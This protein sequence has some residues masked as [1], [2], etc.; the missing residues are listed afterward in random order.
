METNNSKN[1]LEAES[2]PKNF[3]SDFDESIQSQTKILKGL[4]RECL[5]SDYHIEDSFLSYQRSY[6]KNGI[7]LV[8]YIHFD[9]SSDIYVLPELMTA[10]FWNEEIAI[11]GLLNG[12]CVYFLGQKKNKSQNHTFCSNHPQLVQIVQ[13]N[14]KIRFH[15]DFHYLS[16]PG[17]DRISE[18]VGIRLLNDKSQFLTIRNSGKIASY[19]RT[20]EPFGSR[21][22]QNQ[23]LDFQPE[24]FQPIKSL[25]LKLSS[26]APGTGTSVFIKNKVT[27]IVYEEE[28]FAL[29]SFDF[30][31]PNES[32]SFI[33]N[34]KEKIKI[35]GSASGKIYF[36]FEGNVFQIQELDQTLD[37]SIL[38]IVPAYYS[39]Y[40]NDN[41][42]LTF[43]EGINFLAVLCS[44]L[45]IYCFEIT[46]E[47]NYVLKSSIR[48]IS[49]MKVS[50]GA[51]DSDFE[52]HAL[53]IVTHK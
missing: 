26:N 1:E 4:G 35:I 14:K 19:S 28:E 44:D 33:M 36:G 2:L 42:D 13:K 22:L 16:D 9:G 8:C 50:L 23:A 40:E 51:H 34:T 31:F 32:I 49:H 39:K 52:N 46:S 53:K 27:D 47:R 48:I 21:F 17:F 18:I 5:I 37:S 3:S 38:R 30:P 43:V 29:E 11:F 24:H 20:I 41:R 7:K 6:P 45:V 12:S 25:H 10:R 15:G